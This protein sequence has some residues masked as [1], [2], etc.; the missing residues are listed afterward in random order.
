RLSLRRPISIPRGT[1]GRPRP[2]ESQRGPR[3]TSADWCALVVRRVRHERARRASVPHLRRIDRE[4][5]AADDA[6]METLNTPF[7]PFELRWDAP[8]L[9]E[10][11]VA[12]STSVEWWYFDLSTD[13]GVELV[14]IFGRKNP[15]WSASK[16]SMY[17]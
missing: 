3:R 11:D 6:H 4:A 8:Q 2:R 14:V 5:P 16:V 15:M 12:R 7:V 1:V 17:L 10:Q 13:D 9:T